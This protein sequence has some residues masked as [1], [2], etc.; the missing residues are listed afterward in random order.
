MGAEELLLPECSAPSHKA[1]SY[2]C[3]K[4]SFNSFMFQVPPGRDAVFSSRSL[5]APE[6]KLTNAGDER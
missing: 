6:L 2:L 3:A 4:V 1:S 5:Q